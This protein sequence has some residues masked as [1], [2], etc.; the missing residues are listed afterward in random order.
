MNQDRHFYLY[1]KYHYQ[2]TDKIK[3]LSVIY[4]KVYGFN[5][6]DKVPITYLISILTKLASVHMNEY[7]FN[8]FTEDILPEN[9]WKHGYMTTK[10]NLLYKPTEKLPP[11]DVKKA[12]ISKLLSILRLATVKEIPFELGVADES[13]LPLKKKEA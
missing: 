5:K 11:Y 12:I 7:T 3:D 8:S 1:A 6:R 13:I 9:T 4:N 2:S 10:S